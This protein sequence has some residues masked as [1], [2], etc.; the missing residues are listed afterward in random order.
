MRQIASICILSLLI[1]CKSVLVYTD[2]DS[3]V[4]YDNDLS[5]FDYLPD[6]LIKVVTYNIHYGIPPEEALKE[7]KSHSLLDDT[8]IFLLQ[9]MDEV[10]VKYLAE[11]LGLNFVYYPI[12]KNDKLDLNFGNAVL[13]KSKILEHKKVILPHEKKGNGRKRHAV[14][15]R[16]EMNDQTL[17]ICN[18]HTETTVMR[19]NKRLNQRLYIMNYINVNIPDNEFVIVGGD[20]NTF[21]KR[22]LMN[23]ISKFKEGGYTHASKEVNG[24]ARAIFNIFNPTLDHI[25]IKGLEVIS[26]GKEDRSLLSDHK[27]VFVELK[28]KSIE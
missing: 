27:P 2:V 26:S 13:L 14:F 21:F 10:G 18:A 5:G 17:W 11:N 12:T 4:F 6:E 24:T 15:C 3:P 23:T 9:E 8:D 19:R 28:V 22:D 25:F 7:I 1:S 20:L 16:T